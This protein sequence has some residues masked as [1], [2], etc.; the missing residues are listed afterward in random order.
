MLV[1]IDDIDDAMQLKN[2]LPSCELHPNSLVIVTSRK[3]NIF[4]TCCI[5]VSEVHL[6]PEGHDVQLF[7]AWAFAS[8]TPTW[9]TSQLIED[10]V[11]CC[12]RLP[13]TLKVGLHMPCVF[14]G[15]MHMH[16]FYQN[17]RLRVCLNDAACP[18]MCP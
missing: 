11:A 18:V 2:L 12:G 16:S 3:Q 9:R 13:L 5:K 15:H 6:L 17:K 1:V 14:S 4:V 10:M 7:K 8:G